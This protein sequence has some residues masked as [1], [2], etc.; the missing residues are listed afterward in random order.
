M[1]AIYK[2]PF[3]FGIGA[4]IGVIAAA[5]LFNLLLSQKS[6]KKLDDL[7]IGEQDPILTVPYNGKINYILFNE[8]VKYQRVK[9]N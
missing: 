7:I 5:G 8:L 2:I 4:G 3:T 6:E 9:E 1:K